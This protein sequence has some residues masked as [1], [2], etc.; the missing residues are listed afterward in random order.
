MAILAIP[1]ERKSLASLVKV[2]R[3]P[4]W[5]VHPFRCNTIVWQTV[6]QPPG[7]IHCC[8]TYMRRALNIRG[9]SWHKRRESQE[10]TVWGTEH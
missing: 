6:R 1:V 9:L 2:C 8:A 4:A 5:F 7:Q 10:S 3:K